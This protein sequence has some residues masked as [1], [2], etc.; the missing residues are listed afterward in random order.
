LTGDRQLYVLGCRV[1][2]IDAT[3]AADRLSLWLRQGHPA[4]VVTL[5][6]EMATLATRDAAYR[7]AI[8]GADL[9]VP[10]TVG[11]VWA[12]RVLRR[13]L[14]ER[15]AGIDLIERVLRDSPPASVRVFILGAAAGVADAA[16]QA[17][18]SRFPSVVICGM[19]HGFFERDHD[20]E[21]A[22]VVRESGARLVLVG[23]GF[24]LQEF[25][26][27]KN[28]AALGDAVCIGVGGALDVW[29]G[30]ATRAPEAW[31]RAGLE[32]LYRLVREPARFRRQL[33]LPRFAALV[34][35][36]AMRERGANQ[37]R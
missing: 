18:G 35:A 13:P 5:G 31:R 23:M 9:I 30:R 24:P 33:A 3:S 29:A 32:W 37:A 8:N 26:I 20:A 11:I 34:L 12:S 25:W 19:H 17:L 28:L 21:V 6:A 2:D 22:H 27:Q 36:Q 10:D 16:A 14:R 4:H 15:V 1:D 7:A